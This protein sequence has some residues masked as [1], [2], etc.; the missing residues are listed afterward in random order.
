MIIILLLTVVFSKFIEINPKIDNNTNPPFLFPEA[1]TVY[2]KWD[3]FA[4][5]FFSSATTSQ[6]RSRE[7]AKA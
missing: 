6:T 4:D 2:K 7:T 1:M 3:Y 5:P